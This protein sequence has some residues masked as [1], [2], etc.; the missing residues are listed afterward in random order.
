M[1]TEQIIYY[2]YYCSS[3]V[4]IRGSAPLFWEQKGVTSNLKLS[5]NIDLTNAAFV[6]HFE[7]LTKDYKRILCINLMTKS[8]SEQILTDAYENLIQKNN[9]ENIRYEFFDFHSACK[10][11]KYENV[12]FLTSKLTEIIDNFKF[13]AEQIKKDKKLLLQQE[14]T[15]RINCLDCL[16]RTNVVMTKIAA[17]NF[18]NMMKHVNTN[19][20]L[21]LGD[22]TL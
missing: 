9:F 7:N 21:A 15:I 1:E 2:S 22:K 17:I 3:F 14:G 11:Q 13:F 16:D 19:L 4:L 8:K 6:K 12:D 5:R 10:G 20:S 18:E